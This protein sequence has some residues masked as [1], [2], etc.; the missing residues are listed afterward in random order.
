MQSKIET[1]VEIEITPLSS[2]SSSITK[3][4]A[5]YVYL[6]EKWRA[7]KE[8][9]LELSQEVQCEGYPKIFADGSHI[10]NR[11]IWTFLFVVLTGITC[12]LLTQN[13]LDYL[14]QVT[15]TKTKNFKYFINFSLPIW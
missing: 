2:S 8:K 9:F 5:K 11:L 10:V 13:V 3:I 12:Y 4:E 7:T 6:R 1:N 15:R 14:R